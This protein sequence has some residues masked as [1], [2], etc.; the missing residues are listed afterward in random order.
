MK[1]KLKTKLSKK[2]LAEILGLIVVSLMRR[3]SLK[4]ISITDEPL[5]KTTTHKV[6]RFIEMKKI[7]EIDS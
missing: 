7:E 2:N 1:T 4:E 5:E 6:K 3:L